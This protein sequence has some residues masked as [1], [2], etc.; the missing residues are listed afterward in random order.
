VK[1]IG[2]KDCHISAAENGKVDIHLKLST[3][4]K[5]HSMASDKSK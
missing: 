1:P 2:T 5:P 4:T 3:K